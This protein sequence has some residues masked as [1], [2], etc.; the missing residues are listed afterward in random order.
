MT[1]EQQPYPPEVAWTAWANA[2]GLTMTAERISRETFRSAS[3]DF[4]HRDEKPQ[5]DRTYWTLTL[6]NRDGATFSVPY[7]LGS[8]AWWNVRGTMMHRRYG[9][10]FRATCRSCFEPWPCREL[11]RISLT[12]HAPAG[13]LPTPPT[14][15]DLLDCLAS[16]ASGYDNAR[17][18]DDWCSE[19]GYDTDSRTAVRV[20]NA[21][22]EQAHQLRLLLGD[23]A[24]AEALEMERL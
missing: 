14:I 3:P 4:E 18:F 9:E 13:S 23:A 20:Y 21:I 15:A 6:A 19:Y 22:A 11:V 16:D 1:A 8:S 7:S 5:L 24:Y 17:A 12:N 10:Q 2:H